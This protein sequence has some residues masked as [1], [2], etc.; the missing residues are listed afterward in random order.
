MLH[1]ISYEIARLNRLV[2]FYI[3]L[4]IDSHIIMYIDIIPFESKF[5]FY[6]SQ[7]HLYG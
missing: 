1:I 2:D 4:G 7:V 3:W 6:D 5:N